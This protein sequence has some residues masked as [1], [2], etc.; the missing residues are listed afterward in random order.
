MAKK[1]TTELTFKQL[2]APKYWLT[3]LAMSITYLVSFL[4]WR[5]KQTLGKYL[6]L[7]LHKTA[8]RRRHICDVNLQ[9]CYPDM[10]PEERKALTRQHFI[11]AGKGFL[12]TFDAWYQPASKLMPRVDFDSQAVVDKALEAGKGCILISGHF[13]PLDLCGTLIA[14]HLDL[15]PIYKRQNNPVFNWVM[16]HQRKKV[17]SKT[18]ERSDMREVLKSLKLNKPVWYAVDQDYGRKHSVF[19]PFFGR[20]CA[21]ISHIGRIAKMTKAPVLMLDYGRTENGYTYRFTEVENYP[22]EDDVTNATI[23]NKLMEDAISTKKEQY[24]WSHRRFK[25]QPVKGD[26]SPYNDK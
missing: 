1:S 22:T 19:A 2:L 8:A 25:T 10:T 26:P 20:E 16:E 4:P 15:H 13:A 24:L 5:A 17:Y 11:S 7:L 23:I 18:I 3:W 9:I 6:G 21:T 12:E 14:S